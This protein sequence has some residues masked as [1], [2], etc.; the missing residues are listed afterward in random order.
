MFFL[1]KRSK[2]ELS[3]LIDLEKKK[4]SILCFSQVVS[5]PDTR[6]TEAGL[7][8]YSMERK[9]CFAFLSSSGLILA[10]GIDPIASFPTPLANFSHFFSPEPP[11]RFLPQIVYSG[12]AAESNS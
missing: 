6:N 8:L 3:F 1:V 12:T 2:K 10:P 7:V 11:P 4:I 5:W 9:C